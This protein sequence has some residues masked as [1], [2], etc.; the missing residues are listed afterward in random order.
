MSE[1]KEPSNDGGGRQITEGRQQK[2]IEA[3]WIAAWQLRKEEGC[4]A[5]WR[6]L[7]FE[8]P[9]GLPFEGVLLGDRNVE[10]RRDCDCR[11]CALAVLPT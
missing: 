11:S 2:E 4:Q 1:L 6:L 7:E 5:C 3:V 9:L 10:L 8:V